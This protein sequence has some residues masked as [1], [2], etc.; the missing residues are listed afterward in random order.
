ML[1]LIVS[2]INILHANNCYFSKW[3]LLGHSNVILRLLSRS[4]ALLG[5]VAKQHHT[6]KLN[7]EILVADSKNILD[8]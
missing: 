5:L 1:L 8:M 7:S 4:D 6:E 2:D 3:L